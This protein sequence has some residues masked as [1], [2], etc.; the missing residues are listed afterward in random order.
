[1]GGSIPQLLR[2][3]HA[4]VRGGGA[5][6]RHHRHPRHSAP[7]RQGSRPS[8]PGRD[9]C[10]GQGRSLHPAGAVALPVGLGDGLPARTRL[11]LARRG[12]GARRERARGAGGAGG[13]AVVCRRLLLGALGRRQRMARRPGRDAV[14]H[15]A[16]GHR[17]RSRKPSGDIDL[18]QANA[19]P[20]L[21]GAHSS[22]GCG[23]AGPVRHSI[24]NDRPRTPDRLLRGLERRRRPL[25]HFRDRADDRLR[26]S[27]AA[28]CRGAAA[29]GG[30]R[31]C[32]DHPDRARCGGDRAGAEGDGPEE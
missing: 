19:A 27:H 31:F 6:L 15:P 3:R 11:G 23:L 12:G 29:R 4:G 5:I 7:G 18:R 24:R 30:D 16:R 2:A 26:R 20:L 17:D 25:L 21:R 14:W 9:P 10:G 13:R 32:R 1:M 22:T 28:S 8:A